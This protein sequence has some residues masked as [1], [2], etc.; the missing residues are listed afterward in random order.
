MRRKLLLTI[1]I[2]VALGACGAPEPYP[3]PTPAFGLPSLELPADEAP[4]D[5]QAEWWYFNL[6]LIDETG[7]RYALHDVVFQVQQ[8]ES[9]RTLYVRQIGLGA[10]ASSTHHTAERLRTTD[11][12][13]TDVP[14]DFKIVIG[15]GLVTGSDGE[16]YQLVGSADSIDYDLTLATMAGFIAHDDDGLVDLGESGVTYYYSR[17][18]LEVAG[19]ISIAGDERTVTGLGWLDKQWGNFQPVEVYWD[20]ASVQLED[21]TDLMLT[22]LYDMERRS[23]DVYATLRRPGRREQRLNADEFTFQPLGDTWYSAR[24]ETTYNTHWEVKVP[25]E[26]IEV[27][28]T[29][30]IVESEFASTFLGVAYWEAGVDVID[31]AGQLVGQ[32]FVELNWGRNQAFVN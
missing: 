9:S 17:P 22:N 29:P 25:S 28:L 4:H 16:R 5:F 26:G 14:G 31:T 7:S 19:T 3:T 30:L 20:W 8:L 32:G 2:A 12:P 21:G 15:G 6:H 13:L 27:L 11:E 23:I 1:S 24:T 18:R 10:V